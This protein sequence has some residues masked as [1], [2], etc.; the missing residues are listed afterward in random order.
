MSGTIIVEY[1]DSVQLCEKTG[2]KRRLITPL[3]LTRVKE[4][5]RLGVLPLWVRQ[6]N[7]VTGP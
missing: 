7:L 1:D 5:I 6:H 3:W 4:V 2:V